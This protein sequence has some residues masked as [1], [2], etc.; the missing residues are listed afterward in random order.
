MRLKHLTTN[1][2]KRHGEDEESDDEHEN[3][4]EDEDEFQK[5]TRATAAKE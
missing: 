1:G 2:L 4:E 5:I 3:E